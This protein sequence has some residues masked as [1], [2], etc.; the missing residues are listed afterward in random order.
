M[1]TTTPGVQERAQGAASTA[2]DEG[3]HVAGVAQEE[4]SKVASEAAQQVKGVADDALS[5]VADQMSEQARTQRD[6]VVGLLQSFGDDL[7][8]MVEQAD[9][10]SLA[11][12]AAREAQTR[13]RALGDRLDGREPGELLEDLRGFARQRPGTFLLGALAAGV[14][15]GR[16]LRGARDGAV[17]ASAEPPRATG[18]EYGAPPSASGVPTTNPPMPS[19]TPGQPTVEPTVTDTLAEDGP[20]GTPAAGYGERGTTPGGPL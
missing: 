4:A 13:A 15:A 2:T 14:V 1:T 5:Q 12:Q 18:P 9:D 7:G 8:R 10:S 11:T 19:A 3:R 16:L 20:M 17:A 6:R